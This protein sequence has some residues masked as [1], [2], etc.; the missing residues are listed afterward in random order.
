MRLLDEFALDVIRRSAVR[1]DIVIEL[2]IWRDEAVGHHST[3]SE[4]ALTGAAIAFR[5]KRKWRYW[6]VIVRAQLHPTHPVS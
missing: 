3:L 2:R 1:D 6:Q 4:I 5:G